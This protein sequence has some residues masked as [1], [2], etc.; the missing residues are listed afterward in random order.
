MYSKK[1]GDFN[2]YRRILATKAREEK[3]TKK[4]GQF[5]RASYLSFKFY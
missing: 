3:E 4:P 1:E 5:A 2:I